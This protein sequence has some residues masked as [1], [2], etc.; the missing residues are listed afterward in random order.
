[1]IFGAKFEGDQLEY[2]VWGNGVLLGFHKGVMRDG[3]FWKT[4]GEAFRQGVLV[5][6]ETIVN[7][8]AAKRSKIT[9]Q[10]IDPDNGEVIRTKEISLSY[11]PVKIPGEDDDE[12]DDAADGKGV[13]VPLPASKG[14]ATATPAAPA[15][16]AKEAAK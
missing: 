9:T 7:D 15:A 1:M 11:L 6:K 12:D 10:D 16:P 13:E 4:Y 14:A 2:K 8:D 5:A 3:V